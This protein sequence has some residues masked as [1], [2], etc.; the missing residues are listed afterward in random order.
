[1]PAASRGSSSAHDLVQQ[2]VEVRGL[3]L[4]L[5]LRVHRPPQHRDAVA[6]DVLYD[7]EPLRVRD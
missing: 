1:L 2:A 4:Q 5:R 7:R 6:A 3:G